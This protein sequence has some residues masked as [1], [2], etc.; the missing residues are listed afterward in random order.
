MEEIW[1]KIE[2]FENYEISNFGKVRN[3]NYNNLGI[4]KTLLTHNRVKLSKNNQT[5]NFNLNKLIDKYFPETIKK[6]DNIENEIW[7]QLDGFDEYFISNF[8]RFKTINY[9]YT[10]KEQLLSSY[11]GYIKINKNKKTNHFNLNKLVNLYFPENITVIQNSQNDIWKEINN[12]PN[13]YVSS[14]GNIK[15]LNYHNSGKEQLLILHRQNNGY[16]RTT[17]CNTLNQKTFYVHRLVAEAFLEKSENK[18]IVNHKNFIRDDNRVENL[19]WCSY[20]D[21][22]KHSYNNNHVIIKH[23]NLETR[24]IKQE[25]FLEGEIWKKIEGF[26]NYEISN[27]ARVKSLKNNK[28]LKNKITDGYVYINIL[29]KSFRV[30]RLVALAFLENPENKPF[31]NHIDGN[32]LNNRVENLNWMTQ[33][34]NMQ[35]SV[36]ILGNNIKKDI[37]TFSHEIYG[38]EKCTVYSLITKYNLKRGIYNLISG[39][40]KQHKGWTLIK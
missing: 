36:N 27:F 31:V 3:N 10:G 19:E 16:M 17:L 30:H 1:K 28:I 24:K 12:F 26:P 23:K 15:N 39:K 25:L 2:G 33:E 4:V 34:E 14:N 11:N 13:Y 5:T 40:Y 8:K 7:K 22:V 18:E 29:Y 35:H 6:I 38:I 21:N 32:K 37:Y 20:S 9:N